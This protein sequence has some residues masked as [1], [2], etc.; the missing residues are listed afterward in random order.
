VRSDA[1]ELE[2]QRL[3]AHAVDVQVVLAREADGARELVHLG[4]HVT[5]RRLARRL[6]HGQGLAFALADAL[7]LAFPHLKTLLDVDPVH[8]LVIDTPAFAAQQGMDAP[9]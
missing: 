8:R 3:Q 7:S 2:A 6:R 5:R 9:L 1:A 4:E